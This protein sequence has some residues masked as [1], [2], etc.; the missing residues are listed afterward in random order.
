MQSSAGL[1]NRVLGSAIECW[2]LW[3]CNDKKP[4][5]SGLFRQSEVGCALELYPWGG[6][7]GQPC[8]KLICEGSYC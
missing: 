6:K 4:I 7:A 8:V 1:C 3:L 2:V 5:K